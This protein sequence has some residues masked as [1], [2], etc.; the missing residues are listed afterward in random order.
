MNAL[1]QSV[2]IGVLA[3]VQN[4]LAVEDEFLCR[5][6]FQGGHDFRKIAVEPLTRFRHHHDLRAVAKREATEAVPL[7]LVLPFAAFR[8]RGS[9]RCFHGKSF[10]GRRKIDRNFARSQRPRDCKSGANKSPVF[11]TRAGMLMSVKSRGSMPCST[12]LHV[13]GAETVASSVGRTE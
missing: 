7:G 11:V 12:S 2:E 10:S 8:N 6:R 1:K 9:R 3:V 13:T 4:Q 5:D